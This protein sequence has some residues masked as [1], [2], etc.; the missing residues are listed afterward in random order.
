MEFGIEDVWPLAPLQEGLLFHAEYE[1]EGGDV[2]NRQMSID[3]EGEIDPAAL[4][5]AAVTL[6]RRH[7]NLRAGFLTMGA[8][9]PVQVVAKDV[10]VPWREVDVSDESAETSEKRARAVAEEEYRARFDMARPPLV[11]FVLLRLGERRHRLVLTNHHIL[12]DGWS[13]PLLVRELVALYERGGD[14]TGLAP[15]ASYRAYVAW[16]AGQDRDVAL[17]A[18]REA[19]AGLSAPSLLAPGHEVARSAVRRGLVTHRLPQ[20]LTSRL[21]E[22]ARARG[23]TVNTVMQMCWALL[24]SGMTGREDVV[25]G[26]TVSG[27]PAELA[28]VDAMVGLFINTLPLR[29]RLR[30]DEPVGDLA[31]RIQGEQAALLPHQHLGLSHIQR[32]A[33]TDTGGDLFDTVMVFQN[34]PH[35]GQKYSASA[36][37]LTVATTGGDSPHYSLALTV[38]PDSALLFRLDYRADLF[39]QPAVA[40]LAARLE[41]LVEQAV[42]DPQA[43]AGQLDLLGEDE[44]RLLLTER[45]G[46]TDDLLAGGWVELFQAQVERTPD[47]VALVGPDEDE[48]PLT[49]RE[50]DE[51]ANRLAHWLIGRAVGPED[52]VA[53]AVPRGVRMMVATLAVLKAGAAYLPIDPDHP[54]DRITSMVQDVRPRLALVTAATAEAL[55]TVTG[56]TVT[57]IDEPPMIGTLATLPATRPTDEDRTSPLRDT[58]PAYIIFTSGSTGGPK[59]VVVPHRGLANYV[60]WLQRTCRL[61][62]DDRVLL[63]TPVT[64][65]G[66]VIELF[67]PLTVGARLVLAKPGG[68]QDAHYL[69]EVIATEQ[70]TCVQ[71][72]PS[73]LD[74]FVD[75]PAAARCT[76][77]RQVLCG[78]E[79]LPQD[80]VDRVTRLL[81]V[82]V[83][84]LY[85]PT[86]VTVDATGGRVFADADDG[87]P[88]GRPV[89]N[90]R[91]YVVDTALR[92]VPAGAT[93]E[94]Y[95]AGA[96]LARGYA[97]RAGLTAGRFVACPFE[98]GGE[99][100]Y[101]TGDLVR[102][103]PDGQLEYLGRADD[104]VKIR[105]FRIEPGEIEAVLLRH[106]DVRQAAVVV[107]EDR[108]GSGRNLV[109]YLVPAAPAG[110]GAH[111]AHLDTAS[112][113]DFAM[114]ALPDYMVPTAFVV[115]KTLP[116]TANGKLDRRALPAP[117][118]TALVTLRPPRTPQEEVLCGVFAELL[119][120]PRVG[121]DDDFFALGGQSLLVMRLVARTR[122]LLG[123]ELS[124]RDVFKAPTVAGLAQLLVRDDS[125]RP[126][127]KA[128]QRPERVP[129]SFAQR[130]LWFLYQLE[131]PSTTY[132]VPLTL[133]LSGRLD[134]T[135]L[136]AALADVVGRHESLRT[137]FAEVAGVPF[138]RILDAGEARPELRVSEADAAGLDAR[139]AEAAE[140]RF[141]LGTEMP[142]RAELFT[143]GPDE[144]VLQVLVHHIASDGWSMTPLARDLAA[145]YAAR[146]QGLEPDWPD[147]PVQYA[148]YTLWQR[149]LLGEES[150][151][152]S[153]FA[154]QLA[155]W[156]RQLAG[157]PEHLQLPADRPRP[158]VA[159]HRGDIA[160]V[161]LSP[162]LHAGLADMC[163][164]TGS[165]MFMVLQAALAALF[166]RLG[167]GTDI[168]IGS[169][170]AGRT[171]QELDELVGCFVNTLV[172]RTD[173]SG[174]PTF[175]ELLGRV[176]ENALAAYTHQDVPFENLVEVLNPARSLSYNPLFQTILAL[177]NVPLGEFDLPGLHVS[178]MSMPVRTA[179]FDLVFNLRERY[180]PDGGSGG[181]TGAV[182]YATDLFD[183]ATVE[184]LV[185]R[186]TRLLEAVVADPDTAVS[187]IDMLSDDER[188]RLLHGPA[189]RAAEGVE[190]VVS[191]AFEARVALAPDAVAVAAGDVSLTYGELNLRANRFAHLLRKRGVGAEQIVALV[192]PRSPE[193]LVA[194]LGVLKAGAAYLPVDPEYPRS[195]IEFMLSD[196]RPSL[197]VDDPQTVRETE[198]Y[199][200]TDPEVAVDARQPAY[201]IYTSGSTGRP[202]GVVVSYAGV[203]ALHAASVER[204]AIDDSSRILQFASPSFDASFWDITNALL[205][206]ATLVLASPTEPLTALTDLR[207]AV[208]HVL[209]PP[210]VLAAVAED[211]VPASTTLV[212]GGEACPPGLVERWSPGRRL[213][214]AYG[215]TEAT[216]C[217][218][219]SGPLSVLSPTPPPIGRPIAN[220][221]AFVLD[222][223]LRPV[224]TGVAGELYVAGP[225]LARGY[226]GQP[227]L[228]AERFVA[229]PYG[230]PGSRMY[231]TG[232]V[233]RWRRDGELEFLGRA[234]EQAKVRGFRIEP[235]EIE[236]V[237]A[238]HPRLAQAKVIV[239]QDRPGDKRLVAYVV[240]APIP[241]E[242]TVLTDDVLAHLRE[243][244]P[245]YLVPSAIVVLDRLPLTPNG[246]VDRNALPAPEPVAQGSART[247][248]EQP[249][250]ARQRT[251]CE[252]FAETLG[253]EETG[254]DDGFFALGG[255]S[256]LTVRLVRAIN[257][258]FGTHLP[259]NV[260]FEH[261]TPAAL[262]ALLGA[263]GTDEETGAEGQALPPD[264]AA[265]ISLDPSITAQGG[266]D[267]SDFAAPDAVLL[268]GATGFVGSFI[269][270]EVLERTSAD[271]YCLVRAGTPADALARLRRSQERYG[272]WD[273]R[274]GARIVPVPGDLAEPLL[275]L[276]A[277]RF[278]DLARRINVV[279]HNGARVNHLESYGQLRA[280]NVSGVR[281]VFRLAARHRIKPVH[282]ISTV[283]TLAAA[284]GKDP[285]TL[286][287]DWLSPPDAIGTNGYVCTK[288]VGEAIGRLARDRGIPTATYRL[289]RISGHTETGA[290][291]PDDAFW[292]KVRACAEI[293]AR[294]VRDDGTVERQNLVPVDFAARAFVHLALTQRPD[295]RIYNIAAPA[296][297]AEDAVLDY[298]QEFGYPMERVS[299]SVWRKRVEKAA[300][301]TPV[302]R[303]GSLH[304]VAL[305]SSGTR[306]VPGNVPTRYDRRNLLAGLA[307]AGWDFPAVGPEILERYF[308]Y[309]VAGGLLPPPDRS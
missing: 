30:A 41:R 150:D 169:P 158:P 236:A 67:W 149:E 173:T 190:N 256:L 38:V 16:L 109:A 45:T 85:G 177:Q 290:M 258:R 144:Q 59:G 12:W 136:E 306:A 237:L 120:L 18:W 75:E 216:V 49:Y 294:P 166:T 234:D 296:G 215:P 217:A 60:S 82:E 105:G 152:G 225:G 254:L 21:G 227:G 108:P 106:T 4:H 53:I 246:K 164:R 80:V 63:K 23:V 259:L 43:R 286:P 185:A 142:L 240:A 301:D 207:L 61:T 37:K 203:G 221:N 56:V 124:A 135:A 213:V 24:L 199:P 19:L 110:A 127:L 277:D 176:R 293:G 222:A 72:V 233:V 97:G 52:I 93:G 268:T 303:T 48:G 70:V 278:D 263:D 64:F 9:G 214:N 287:E 299:P 15:A 218:T 230:P 88:I 202:K 184:T 229:G 74:V 181:V 73:M 249:L 129:L 81:P 58:H 204:L 79:A 289:A 167:A 151:A 275:G 265:E 224:P 178:T 118:S 102:R 309:F 238:A 182:E 34:Y 264:L 32:L 231:R 6:L 76:S 153:L 115:L 262:D 189:D 69:T 71:F 273:D 33:D 175:S 194:V 137:V 193:L 274:F 51:R 40:E 28:D 212:V 86:E 267:G 25:F 123:A 243:R 96:G 209:V 171:D 104:Q 206:G 139:L 113:R 253:V 66:S 172:I 83:Y 297:T 276:P 288:W 134:R 270:R 35:A 128:V 285:D 187:R 17:A 170:I 26:I 98:P 180:R 280:T 46:S 20:A 186:W 7:P 279:Y 39:D 140:Y 107:R 250:T 284:P 95:V 114:R 78:G 228:T 160:R 50:L 266:Y 159:S 91:L 154:R 281:E 223:G 89:A 14:D 235:G 283:G 211:D 5:A 31:A 165:S 44:R 13:L 255:H 11:R 55:P 192:L 245:E 92:L 126:A 99:R 141:D 302:S 252:L 8:S 247:P 90:T 183:L 210:S 191:K 260:I 112:V 54:T 138:Q 205:S 36:A 27:R 147:L 122:A 65:D 163:R 298:A 117:D 201:V 197:I 304:A 179:K 57:V 125:A 241:Q 155:Y 307:D 248:R 156:T 130:R 272:L 100:M 1:A 232:D 208:T 10:T 300:A 2:Y 261:E 111:T 143:L 94:L 200:E 251:L 42:A 131:G 29:V 22:W 226:L 292:H 103:R 121:V 282:Q 244:L 291:G 116:L 145:A 257:Q 174:D 146:C 188:A 162:E 198:A 219:M 271:V 84:N 133:R 168:P 3:L 62:P 196:A 148:D 47:A 239:R 157:L 295:G 269:L 77:L 119:G 68:H 132:N 242:S 161:E 87:V 305:L 101:R 195:R 308:S 220:T